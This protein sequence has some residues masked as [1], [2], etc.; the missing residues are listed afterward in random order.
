MVLD[1]SFLCTCRDR[2][3][4]D[5]LRELQ[6]DS[7]AFLLRSLPNWRRVV[8]QWQHEHAQAP[9]IAPT[10]GTPACIQY[11]GTSHLGRHRALLPVRRRGPA[12]Q[13]GA[14]AGP[15]PGRSG[16]VVA[17]Q[18][19]SQQLADRRAQGLRDHTHVRRGAAEKLVCCCRRS[20]NPH[21]AAHRGVDG[22]VGGGTGV[23]DDECCARRCAR[24]S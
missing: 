1:N 15:V 13:A 22:G 10:P 9:G 17:P 4:M 6:A 19:A 8:C 24:V 14:P 18:A 20:N 7:T 3:V 21:S 5:C 16:P 11:P 2:H 23:G 12:L